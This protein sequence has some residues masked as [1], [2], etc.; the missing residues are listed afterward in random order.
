MQGERAALC[1][2]SPPYAQQRTYRD[3]ATAHVA[4]WDA[5]MQGVFA[6]APVH[7]DAQIVVNLGLVYR[8]GRC[9][10]YWL[11]W[12]D[13]MEARGWR[14][15]GWYIWD[16]LS[17][18]PGDFRGRFAPAHEF[19]FHFNRTGKKPVKFLPKKPASIKVSHGTALRA[20]DGRQRKVSSPLASLAT[21][22]IPDSVVRMTRAT[23]SHTPIDHPAIFP[24]ALPKFIMQAWPGLVY[25]PFGG[26]GTSLLAAEELGQT[27]CAMEISPHYCDVAIQRW[28]RHTGLTAQRVKTRS[29]A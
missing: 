2:T 6:A 12:L 3:G 28:Q 14:F 23:A 10:Q 25:E 17:G 20:V 5:L 26:S 8:K 22:K 7:D 29:A 15:F 16:K 1:C 27:C 11:K 21:T 18:L 19:L 13:W 9:E 24:V 4:D